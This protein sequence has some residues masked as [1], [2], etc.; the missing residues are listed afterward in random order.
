M[1][2][3]HWR[4]ILAIAQRQHGLV[5]ASQMRKTGASPT[6]IS[7]AVHDGHLQAVRNRVASLPGLPHDPLRDAR[8]VV[9]VAP[10]AVISHRTAGWC[11]GL[12]RQPPSRV[13]LTVRPGRSLTLVG[14]EPHEC[15]L[16]KEHTTRHDGLP[17]TTPAR[18]L[19]D[20]AGTLDDAWVERL[21]HEAV[22][23]RLC[24]YDDLRETAERASLLRAPGGPPMRRIVDDLTGTTPL[25]AQWARHLRD[26]GL[27]EP[28]EQY[29]VVVDGLV[30]VLD[31]AWPDQRVALEANGFVAHRTRAAFDRDH[32]K[33]LRLRAAGWDIHSVTAK[34][35][36]GPVL[37]LLLSV[38]HSRGCCGFPGGN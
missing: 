19:V 20:L 33:V 25:E 15:R 23:R 30:F 22:M 11:H 29:Q 21:V 8:A 1:N 38:I 3:E 34:T 31:F 26:S 13:E 9:L 18:T 10:D 12:L 4:A 27:P 5:T 24:E 2:R 32:D 16:P 35:D 37:A 6:A 14:V 17:V 7:R 36:P 28:V